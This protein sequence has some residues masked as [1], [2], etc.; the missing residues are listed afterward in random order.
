MLKGHL[1]T[2]FDLRGLEAQRH[3][4]GRFSAC[5]LH[6]RPQGHLPRILLHN[7]FHH[8]S[9]HYPSIRAGRK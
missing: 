3:R 6:F 7:R 9:R 2:R 5:P 4:L 1:T 8:L